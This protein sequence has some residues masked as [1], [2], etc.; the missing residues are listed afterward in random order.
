MKILYTADAHEDNAMLQKAGRFGLE[1]K[2]DLWVANGD[3]INTP[4]AL[5]D[6]FQ[7]YMDALQELSNLREQTKFNGS[8]A[9]L[10]LE[11]K[12]QKE[13][14]WKNLGETYLALSNSAKD[15][16][17]EKYKKMAEVFDGLEL[18]SLTLPGNYDNNELM[19]EMFENSLHLQKKDIKCNGSN[20]TIAGYG[21][22]DVCPMWIPQ[23]LV[24]PF[25]EHFKYDEKGNLTEINSEALAFFRHNLPN[26]MLTHAPPLRVLDYILNGQAKIQGDNQSRGGNYALNIYLEELQ[27]QEEPSALWLFGHMHSSGVNRGVKKYSRTVLI[28]PGS[29]SREFGAV[30][31]TCTFSIIDLDGKDKKFEKAVIY[32]IDDPNG[33]IIPIEEYTISKRGLNKLELL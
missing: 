18:P 28:N 19:Q 20:L 6:T 8:L 10:A 22:A 24:V 30:K 33:E 32:G 15:G 1:Q 23:E 21:G 12:N 16:M 11:L 31:G 7:K 25:N 4:W 2:V 5:Q 29:L 17:A 27:K 13:E 9:E 3:F 14:G 26:I